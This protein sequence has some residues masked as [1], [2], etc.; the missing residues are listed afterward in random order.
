MDYGVLIYN[1]IA[2]NSFTNSSN[3]FCLLNLNVN[4]KLVWSRTY[5]KC[6]RNSGHSTSAQCCYRK[7]QQTVLFSQNYE[8]SAEFAFV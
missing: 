8:F 1:K 5:I 3:V 4:S 2:F 6:S 7:Q